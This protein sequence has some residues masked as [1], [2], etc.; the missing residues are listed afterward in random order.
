MDI[1][2]LYIDEHFL[3]CNKPVGISSESPGLPDLLSTQLSRPVFPVH[4]LDVT[5]GGVCILAFT[6]STCSALQ[7]LF[8]RQQISKQYD[9]VVSGIPDTEYGIFRDLLFHD[10]KKNKS[11]IAD[12]KRKGVREAICDWKVLQTVRESEETL[13]L[14]RVTLHT[15]RTHQ[16]RVQFASRG[17][18]LAGDKKY[19]SRIRVQPPSLWACGISFIHPFF[20]DLT[21]R[22]VSRPPMVFP[23]SCF[24]QNYEES[25][26]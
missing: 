6:P 5:T 20:P 1:Q 26:K 9:A 3:I 21:V 18:P 12:T 24:M 15:G 7:S 25:F 13:S 10:R 4:R 16:I 22:A 14:V 23:W 11:Y 19:G 2:L 8:R 17:M